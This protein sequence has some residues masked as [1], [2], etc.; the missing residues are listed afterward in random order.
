MVCGNHGN[1]DAYVVAVD[2]F[3]QMHIGVPLQSDMISVISICER[4][5]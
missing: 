2:K 3:H 4:D 5:R 1:S